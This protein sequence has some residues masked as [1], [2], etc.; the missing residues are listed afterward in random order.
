MNDL[1]VFLLSSHWVRRF[2]I[3]SGGWFFLLAFLLQEGGFF[4]RLPL[5]Q[6]PSNEVVFLPQ[7][8]PLPKY[9]TNDYTLGGARVLEG[10]QL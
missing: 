4:N 6:M 1:S 10:R 2:F 9:Y 8:P 7:F 5:N 3:D